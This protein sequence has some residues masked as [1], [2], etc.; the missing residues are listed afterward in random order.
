MK[1]NKRK[2]LTPQ[3]QE[4]YVNEAMNLLEDVGYYIQNLWHVSDI[5]EKHSGLSQDEA[6]GILNDALTS[7]RIIEEINIEID[8]LIDGFHTYVEYPDEIVRMKMQNADKKS[9]QKKQQGK[10]EK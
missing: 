10:N 1:K 4:V 2:E 9:I 7:A 8:N 5:A 3:Q 6:L